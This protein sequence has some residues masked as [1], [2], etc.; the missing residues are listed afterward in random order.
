MNRYIEFWLTLVWGQTSLPGA[1]VMT[2][3]PQGWVVGCCAA[4]PNAIPKVRLGGTSHMTVGLSHLPLCLHDIRQNL[5][6]RREQW[7][8]YERDYRTISFI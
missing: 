5:L 7:C 4:M 6:S 2:T 8:A 3:K 1:W